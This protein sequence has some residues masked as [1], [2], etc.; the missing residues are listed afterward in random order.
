ME[1]QPIGKTNAVGYVNAVQD[2]IQKDAR[3]IAN[4][5]A[6]WD[7][8]AATIAPISNALGHLR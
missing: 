2:Y 3:A 8:F 1:G 6:A 5:R 7:P 4:D